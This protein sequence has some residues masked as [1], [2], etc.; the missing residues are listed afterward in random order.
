MDNNSTIQLELLQKTPMCYS[1]SMLEEMND[2]N[3]LLEMLNAYLNL[4]PK[5]LN[6]MK[7]KAAAKDFRNLSMAAHTVKGSLGLLQAQVLVS[8]LTTIEQQAKKEIVEL[9]LIEFTCTRYM[10]LA[11]HLE[12]EQQR[13]ELLVR[14]TNS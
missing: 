10:E 14:E 6:E 1:L 2:N 8:A 12:K 4:L 7:E 13:V 9:D 11:V 5:Q 3:Y